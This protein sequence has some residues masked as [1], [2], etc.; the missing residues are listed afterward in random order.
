[1]SRTVV[2]PRTAPTGISA[3]TLRRGGALVALLVVATVGALRDPDFLTSE[4]L[5]NILRQNAVL[6]LLS[7]GMTFVIISGGIDLS[8]GSI[9]AF[10]SVLSVI[11]AGY[12]LLTAL[13][14]PVIVGGILGLGNGVLIARLRIVPFIATLAM[15]CSAS[16]P[17]RSGMGAKRS[18]RSAGR[19]SQA[20]PSR[21]RSSAPC[22]SAASCCCATPALGEPCTPSAAARTRL[23]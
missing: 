1:M 10:T 3:A 9:L 14:V 23:V 18:W 21:S 16:R 17:L 11:L 7:V 5:L 15:R 19:T 13:I 2:V 8:V 22:S 6:G 20:S 4:N 12:G